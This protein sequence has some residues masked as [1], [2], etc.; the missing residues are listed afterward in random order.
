[1]HILTPAHCVSTKNGD[2]PVSAKL[3]SVYLGDNNA[4]KDAFQAKVAEIIVHPAYC[5]NCLAN[6]LAVL[7][8]K[9]R[10][11]VS[12]TLM[13]ICLNNNKQEGTLV[14]GYDVNDEN[15]S[16]SIQS[17]KVKKISDEECSKKAENLAKALTDDTF[18]LTYEKG[19][20]H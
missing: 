18:C 16:G 8:L 11:T 10:V 12:D 4:S 20:F 1:M 14:T 5:G 2:K 7:K 6:D 13:P 3:V 15:G 19:K 9:E 17:A